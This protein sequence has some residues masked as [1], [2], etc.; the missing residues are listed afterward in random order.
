[1]HDFDIIPG[2]DWLTKHRATIVCHTKRVIFDDLDKPEFVYQD[3]Q[4]GLLA[5]IINTLSDGPSLETL[6][7]VRDFYDVFPKEL[8][9]IPPGHKVKFGIELV[10]GTQPISKAPYRMVPIELKELKEQLQELLDLGFISR[11]Y[12]RGELLFCL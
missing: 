9:G 10:S 7:I 6:P 8:P 4:L 3:S 5:S 11:V 12:L 2:M 1:M